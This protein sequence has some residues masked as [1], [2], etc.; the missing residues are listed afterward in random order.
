MAGSA[1][2]GVPFVII[3]YKEADE[4]LKTHWLTSTSVVIC[5][6]PGKEDRAKK[7]V[8]LYVG[9]PELQFRLSL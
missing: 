3:Q 2:P 7:A 6:V 4:G 1:P 8:S 9:T 5:T